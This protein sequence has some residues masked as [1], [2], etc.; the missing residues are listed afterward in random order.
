MNSYLRQFFVR[1][2]IQCRKLREYRASVFIFSIDKINKKVRARV[3]GVSA[4]TALALFT[5][6]QNEV[7]EIIALPER[8]LRPDDCTLSVR[9]VFCKSRWKSSVV[10]LWRC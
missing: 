8:K 5:L 7:G 2:G 1:E 10:R 6:C 9:A 4:F 3:C